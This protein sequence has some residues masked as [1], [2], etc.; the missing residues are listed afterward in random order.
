[1][2]DLAARV[3]G[4][5]VTLIPKRAYRTVFAST[6]NPLSEGGLWVNGGSPSIFSNMR[7]T[8]GLAFGTMQ[9]ASVPPYIDSTAVLAGAW[10][11]AQTAAGRVYRTGTPVDY[12]EVELHLLTTI[13]D[14]AIT[15][16]EFTYSVTSNPY[17]EIHKWLG[18]NGNVNQFP[19]VTSGTL[20][21]A[22][23]TG[24]WV[25]ATVDNAGLLSLYVDSGSG[26]ALIISGTDTTYTS[27]A[28]GLGHWNNNGGAP[29][30]NSEFGFTEFWART[31][32]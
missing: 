19:L 30:T 32:F 8:P 2:A 25:K 14:T 4:F 15:G 1:M 16:Y 18:G 28:P 13:T 11:R 12:Q 5:G 24:D 20:G 31:E 17:V 23:K 3:G 26:Y 7:S 22:L 21:A 6:E 10:T 29:G 9:G 27:G